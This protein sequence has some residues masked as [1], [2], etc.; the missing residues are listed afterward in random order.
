MEF[1]KDR[2]DMKEE[3]LKTITLQKNLFKITMPESTY[4]EYKITYYWL[5]GHHHHK[6]GGKKRREGDPI[7][8]EYDETTRI[9]QHTIITEIVTNEINKTKNVVKRKRRRNKV[10]G[11]ADEGSDYGTEEDDAGENNLRPPPEIKYSPPPQET[12]KDSFLH[13]AFSKKTPMVRTEEPTRPASVEKTPQNHTMPVTPL[14]KMPDPT[15]NGAMTELRDKLPAKRI[16]KAHKSPE[17]A[18]VV[19]EDGVPK[20]VKDIV[21]TEL[22][23]NLLGLPRASDETESQLIRKR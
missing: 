18:K 2:R 23:S 13:K 14:K 10:N 9:N 22:K 8:D 1:M 12:P 3:M 16:I 17:P 5:G 21:M 20:P 19:M 4:T 7:L 6:K 11:G 15:K